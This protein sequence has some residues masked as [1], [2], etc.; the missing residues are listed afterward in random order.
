MM[1]W[2]LLATVLVDIEYYDGLSAISNAR[3]FLGLSS[4]Y[5]FDRGPLMAWIQMPAE[6]IKSVWALH[7][8]DFRLHHAT[9]ALV[10]GAYLVVVYRALVSQYNHGWATLIAMVTAIASYTF[11]SYAPFLSHD[12]A[13]GA[14]LL[15][16]VIWS[17][18]VARAP[19]LAPWLLIVA[20]GTLAPLVKQTYGVFWIA[21]L[22]AHALP[23]L[24][25]M[26]HQYRSSR[27]AVGVLAAGAAASGMAAWVIYG[28]VL[29]D[30]APDVDVWL[31]PYRNLQ[32]LAHVYDGTDASFPVWIYIK[33]LWAY[34]RLTTLLLIPGLVLSLSGSGLQRRVAIAWIVA[35]IFVHAMPLR[36]VRYIAFLAPLSAFLIVPAVQ[37]LLRHRLA[38][39]V[40]AP[41]LALDIGGAA[42][43]AARIGSAFYRDNQLRALLEPFNAGE[44]LPAPV[45]Y[46][47]SMLSF[48]APEASPLAADR[49]HRIFH[50]GVHH[51]AVLYGYAD[52]EVRLV[53]SDRRL[54]A[55]AP[56]GSALLFTN[57]I[58]ANGP[59]WLPRP[60]V[61]SESL[62]QGLAILR[63]FALQ[64]R[65]D[66]AYE[67]ATGRDVSSAP[68]AG[69][70]L[71]VAITGDT[72]QVHALHQAP[73]ASFVLTGLDQSVVR[74][75]ALT[76]RAFVVE[77]LSP[78][79]SM[80]R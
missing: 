12:L 7:P 16:M 35:I 24:L 18:D 64:R 20:M 31:R 25:Q 50:V 66:G 17:D 56:E 23:A 76:L 47:Q 74:P 65:A 14:L 61:G 51:I 77:R 72:Q 37:M 41:L 30:W 36:E 69:Y 48:A 58:I 54:I 68:A 40:L 38:L 4:F 52:G 78:H 63:T 80:A 60:P 79:P 73:D 34:G 67:P 9:M 59:S 45:F 57:R 39:L 10:H 8:L 44:R 13:P 55:A 22:A 1:G 53:P 21:V 71:P 28:L 3:Y 43:E 19:R 46:T 5:I 6:A 62:V 27:R 32:Y 2:L 75:S 11:F 33:N 49:Y 15:W 42:L 29:A 26:D 70:I